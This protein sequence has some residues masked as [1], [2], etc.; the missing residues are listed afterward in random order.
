M[1]TA[2]RPKLAPQALVDDLGSLELRP[3]LAFHGDAPLLLVRIPPGDTDL[4]LGLDGGPGQP[5]GAR[6]LPFRT[7]HHGAVNPSRRSRPPKAALPS[8]EAIREERARVGSLLEK[9]ACVAVALQK[10]EGGDAAFPDRISVGRA[11]NKDIVLRHA[12]VSKF[13][14]WF[15]VDGPE[16]VHVLDSGS[17]NRTQVNGTVIEPK[18]SVAIVSGDRVQFGAVETLLC[19]PETLWWCVRAGAAQPG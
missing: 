10:R 4:E 5:T 13:H 16:T 2:R 15:E 17:T 18:T 12:S 7:T 19:S 14:A 3:F 11:Q 9:H 8:P 1:T 6:P